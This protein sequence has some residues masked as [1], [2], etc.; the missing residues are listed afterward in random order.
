MVYVKTIKLAITIPA[1]ASA[2]TVLNATITD[3]PSV[4]AVNEVQIP[5]TETWYITDIYVKS[6]PSVDI[7]LTFV[8]NRRRELYR[9]PPVSALVQSNP[10]RPEP[11]V[12]MYQAGE[13]LSVK[14]TTLE[15]NSGTSA[16]TVEVFVDVAVEE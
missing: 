11:P 3:D 7:Q 2:G 1:G 4:G 9:T 14:A 16:V 8:K 13:I 15:A 12:M 6:A 10:S 5:I